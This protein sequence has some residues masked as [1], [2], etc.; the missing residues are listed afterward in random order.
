MKSILR[1]NRT[2]GGIIAAI[3]LVVMASFGMLLSGYAQADTLHPNGDERLITLYDGNDAKSFLTRAT[4]VGDALKGA[5]I[6]VDPNDMVQP[7]LNSQ[8]VARSYDIN[9][10][11]ARP[12]TI[13]D[14]E[15][16]QR[17]MTPY[18]TAE[19]IVQQAN[20]P[21]HDEDKLSMSMDGNLI[22]DGSSVQLTI[23]R[24]TPFMFDLYGKTFQ[25]YTQAK[26]VGGL[27]REKNIK[28]GPNDGVSLADT[29]P[30]TANM[31]VRVWRN[32]KQTVTEQQDVPF[33]TQQIEDTSQP[34][35]YK[36]VQTPGVP[37]KQMVTYE[38]ET[39]N[40]Q[41]I[42]RTVIQTVVTQQP[43]TQVEVIGTKVQLPPGSHTDWMAAAGISPSDYGFVDY[44]ASREG[45]WQPCK[46]Q[47]GA[48][49]CSY[50][51]NGGAMGYGIVQ[52]TPGIKMS[53]AG[54]DWAT[55][56]ITQL[57]WAS[58]YAAKYGGWEGAYNHWV[59]FRSW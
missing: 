40:G 24:A 12:V 46:V 56:P 4:T 10:Y 23:N 49:N 22:E 26:T 36:Q 38:V 19:Q 33:S 31:N 52:A 51:A 17:I 48:I 28:L 45:G 54:S 15:T 35:G 59:S 18:Q 27:L 50:A 32:G 41:E 53:S 2:S 43:T 14:G 57:R 34:V 21:L 58:R 6:R 25:A 29:T 11:R 42:S 13:I 8:L 39:Q 9:I 7:G 16:R 20:I 30:I 5:D 1:K 47:G 37:G 55:N 3:T 44:I